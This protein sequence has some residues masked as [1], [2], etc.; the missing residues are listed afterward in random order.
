MREQSS[1][2]KT[3]NSRRPRKLPTGA[4]LLVNTPLQCCFCQQEHSSQGC[5]VVVGVEARRVKLRRSG[6]CYICLARGH[7][8]RNCRRR[9]KCLSCKG[10]HHIANCPEMLQS[11]ANTS[12]NPSPASN[13]SHNASA[14]NPKAQ[15]FQPA[16]THTMW[17]YSGKHVLPQTARATAFNPI[18]PSRTCTVQ[19]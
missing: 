4:A 1:V 10:R 5:K 15:D 17:T 3:Q 7:M 8:S 13:S 6:R 18:D 16:S 2:R 9:F 19:L 14:L 12:S 11:K